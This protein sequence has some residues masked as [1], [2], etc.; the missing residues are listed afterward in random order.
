MIPMMKIG[1]EEQV[2]NG[3]G[4]SR[5]FNGRQV[6]STTPRTLSLSLFSSQLP[7]SLSLL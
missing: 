1:Q 6:E 5:R 2:L 7:F 3:F 4:E